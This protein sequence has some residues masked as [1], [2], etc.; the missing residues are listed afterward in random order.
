MTE[1]EHATES[2]IFDDVIARGGAPKQK[3]PQQQQSPGKATS[4]D[5]SS[6][7][8]ASA[9]SSPLASLSSFTWDQFTV[10]DASAS[11]LGERSFGRVLKVIL[12]RSALA[13]KVIIPKSGPNSIDRTS[14]RTTRTFTSR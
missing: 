4:T 5:A 8:V 12:N 1:Y 14:T 3:L 10:A 13:V 6:S 2:N 9:S 11:V 7:S